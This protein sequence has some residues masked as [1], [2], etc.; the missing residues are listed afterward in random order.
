ML[1]N[2]NTFMLAAVMQ[3][4]HKALQFVSSELRCSHSFMLALIQNFQEAESQFRNSLA[5]KELIL[6][7]KELRIAELEKELQEERLKRQH[8][9]DIFPQAEAVVNEHSHI[10]AFEPGQRILFLV[11]GVRWTQSTVSRK[12]QFLNG[13]SMFKLFMEFMSGRIDPTQFT[14]ENPLRVCAH[15]SPNGVWGLYSNDNRRLAILLMCQACKRR[16]MERCDVFIDVCG[17]RCTGDDSVIP[18]LLSTA[19]VGLLLFSSLAKLGN[20]TTPIV[21]Y[22]WLPTK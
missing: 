16:Q 11:L 18:Q 5:E 10:E 12:W 6:A 7:T 1:R 3:H 19:S 17:E 22:Y 2:D 13:M 20:F 4:S 14:H 15:C 21:R 9:A 8:V